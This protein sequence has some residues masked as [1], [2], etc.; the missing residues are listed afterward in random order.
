VS[1]TRKKLTTQTSCA[2]CPT[3]HTSLFYL[4]KTD[5]STR[6]Q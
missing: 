4:K 6:N 3:Q 1:L 5:F 2:S